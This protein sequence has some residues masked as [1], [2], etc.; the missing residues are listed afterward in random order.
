MELLNVEKDGMEELYKLASIN[1]CSNTAGQIAMDVV[2]NKPKEGDES[3]E[4]FR[5]EY[6]EIYNSLKRRADT[7]G[8]VLNSFEGINCQIVKGAMYAFPTIK[9]PPKAVEYARDECGGMAADALYCLEL[10]E[11]KGVCVVPGSGFGQKDG[12]FHFRTTI[13]PPEDEIEMVA[14]M[15]GEHHRE[16]WQRYS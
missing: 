15:I 4:L 5:E 7:I 8:K 11:N 16:F 6:D 1:L 3:Y 12:T 10:L 9:L 13:L 14:H 2:C